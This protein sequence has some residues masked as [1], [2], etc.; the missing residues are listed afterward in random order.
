MAGSR[1]VV[2][3]L[4]RHPRVTPPPPA[5]PPAPPAPAQ[6]QKTTC[7]HLIPQIGSRYGPKCAVMA[8]RVTQQQAGAGGLMVD[9]RLPTLTLMRLVLA[10]MGVE[11][12]GALKPHAIRARCRSFSYGDASLHLP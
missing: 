9:V 11:R 8:E 7:P 2:R 5:P 6:S 12:I 4:H 10:V 1:A 3:R